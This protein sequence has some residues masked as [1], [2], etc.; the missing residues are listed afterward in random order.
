MEQRSALIFI[1][2]APQQTL[3]IVNG[4]NIYSIQDVINSMA[5]SQPDN[6]TD[7]DGGDGGGE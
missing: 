6:P 3:M 7:M 2:Q 4:R 5:H 1:F